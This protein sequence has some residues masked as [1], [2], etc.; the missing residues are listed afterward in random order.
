MKTDFI[1]H[2]DGDLDAFEDNFEKKLDTNGQAA[3][4]FQTEIDDTKQDIREHR[5][6]YS[7]MNSKKNEAKSFVEANHIR[8]TKHLHR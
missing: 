7:D 8:K 4:L 2:T 1:P 5:N 6:A 3:G